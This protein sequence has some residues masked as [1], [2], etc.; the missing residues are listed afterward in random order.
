MSLSRNTRSFYFGGE[1]SNFRRQAGWVSS[2][3]RAPGKAGFLQNTW[4][5]SGTQGEKLLSS[6]LSCHGL[7][8]RSAPQLAAVSSVTCR[9]C[10]GMGTVPAEGALPWV[11]RQDC[12]SLAKLA[13][14]Q[15]MTHH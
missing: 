6:V 8:E 4:A 10:E 5:A 15:L 1:K 14:V 9:M 3:P 11:C 12:P 2:P 13:S 7:W